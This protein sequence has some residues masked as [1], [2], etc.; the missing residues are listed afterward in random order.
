MKVFTACAIRADHAC[1][2]DKRSVHFDTTSV[3]VYGEYLPAETAGD[4]PEQAA[5]FTITYGVFLHIPPRR[6]IPAQM[7]TVE[8]R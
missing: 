6:Y 8:L 4:Q 3:R 7:A 1:H 5:P 2:F